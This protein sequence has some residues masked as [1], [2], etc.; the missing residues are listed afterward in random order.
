[1]E[2]FDGSDELRTVFE[3]L[4]PIFFE[5]FKSVLEKVIKCFIKLNIAF[6]HVLAGKLV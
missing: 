3:N 1:M 5:D 4:I 6:A 2:G